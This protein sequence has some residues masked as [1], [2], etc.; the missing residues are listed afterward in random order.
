MYG[1]IFYINLYLSTQMKILCCYIYKHRR[2]SK[3]VK[4]CGVF[5][6]TYNGRVCEQLTY[7]FFYIYRYKFPIGFGL[8]LVLVLYKSDPWKKRTRVTEEWFC[9]FVQMYKISCNVMFSYNTPLGLTCSVKCLNQ[10]LTSWKL[11]MG[12]GVIPLIMKLNN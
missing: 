1:E 10:L 11:T 8:L 5:N 9:T 2:I 3:G 4:W 6:M 7:S 12:G